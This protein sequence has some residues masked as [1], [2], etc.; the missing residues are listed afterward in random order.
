[1]AGPLF[2]GGQ[3]GGIEAG[4]IIPTWGRPEEEEEKEDFIS[5]ELLV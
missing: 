5:P 3:K 2:V 4:H 1:V